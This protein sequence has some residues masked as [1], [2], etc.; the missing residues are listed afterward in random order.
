MLFYV[1]C[2]SCGDIMSYNLDKYQQDLSDIV[3]NPKYTRLQKQKYQSELLVKYGI[4]NMCCVIRK[5]GELP[6][7]EII[8]S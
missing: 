7:H 6:Y 4:T 5:L 8:M 3:N 2:P 1:R